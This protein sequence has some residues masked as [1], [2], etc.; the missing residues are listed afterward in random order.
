MA[1]LL[2]SGHQAAI[3]YEERLREERRLDYDDL[4]RHAS[5]LLQVPEVRRLY[6][7]HFGMVMVDEVQDLSVSQ[8][9]MVR[10]VGGDRVTYAGDPAQGIYSFAGADPVGVFAR[11]HDLAPGIVEFNTSYRS[12]PAVLRAVNALAAQMGA[13]QLECG[14]ADGWPDEGHVLSLERDDTDDEAASLLALIDEI[15][16]NPTT[17]IGVVGRRGSR[18]DSL[19]GTADRHGVTFEDWSV[20][21]HVPAVVDLLNRGLPQ[22]V[23]QGTSDA[24]V[25]DLLEGFCRDLVDPADVDTLDEL[26]NACDVLR[27]MVSEGVSVS[28]AVASCH[29]SPRPDAAVAAG[30]HLLTGHKGKG[31]EFDWV[32]VVGLEKGHIP[33]FRSVVADALAEELRVLHVMVSRA[34]YGVVVTYSRHTRTQAG[35]RSSEPS[36]WLSLLRGAAT[37]LDHR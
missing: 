28:D 14:E 32:I 12:A 2:A 25:I 15:L 18:L 34:R 37:D 19:R 21:T 20:A 4:I 26:V 11:I 8:Y 13:T 16:E 9:E 27:T 7:V 5:R 24:D 1:S 22:V 10:A 36:P 3:A 17:T 31:Q 23:G 30:L 29:A 35:W 6:Q 33:D